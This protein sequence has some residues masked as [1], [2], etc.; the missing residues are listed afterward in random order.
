[1]AP[2]QVPAKIFKVLTFGEQR[3]KVHREHPKVIRPFPSKERSSSKEK[4]KDRLTGMLV[5][6]A[7]FCWN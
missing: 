2:L 3:L 5:A 4:V 6:R 1:M 7:R